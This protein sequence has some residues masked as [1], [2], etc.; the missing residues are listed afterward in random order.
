ML[1]K[2]GFVYNKSL[3]TSKANIVSNAFQSFIND[4]NLVTITIEMLA[5]EELK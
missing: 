5:N 2:A 3:F 4:V 1:A